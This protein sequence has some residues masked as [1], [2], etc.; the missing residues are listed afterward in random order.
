[1]KVFIVVEALVLMRVKA[2]SAPTGRSAV[3]DVVCPVKSLSVRVTETDRIN[4]SPLWI[5]KN[6]MIPYLLPDPDVHAI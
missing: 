2:L 1:M 4:P 3:W 5:R 6:P